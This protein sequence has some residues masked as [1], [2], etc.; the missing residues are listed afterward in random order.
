M[1]VDNDL[2][3]RVAAEIS[4][5]GDETVQVE[6]DVATCYALIA[7]L[8]LGCRHPG[9]AGFTRDT[10]IKVAQELAQRIAP[11]GSALAESIAMSWPPEQEQDVH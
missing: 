3:N 10:A 2:R 9:I 7:I 4:A 5:C 6:F 8:Q 1:T 11:P